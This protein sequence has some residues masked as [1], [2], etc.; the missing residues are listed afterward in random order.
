MRIILEAVDAQSTPT[1]S[2]VSFPSASAIV[3]QALLSALLV[4]LPPQAMSGVR[5]S[6][7]VDPK[8]NMPGELLV[9]ITLRGQIPSWAKEIYP[10]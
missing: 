3:G 6:Y 4:R 1:T 5:E 2:Y 9:T 7:P 8:S 10:Q